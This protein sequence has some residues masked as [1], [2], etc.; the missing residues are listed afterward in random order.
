MINGQRK[1]APFKDGSDGSKK[2]AKIESFVWNE[3]VS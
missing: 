3:V 2:L 1:I